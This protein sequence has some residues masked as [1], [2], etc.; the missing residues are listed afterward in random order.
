[1]MNPP[2]FYCKVWEDNQSWI[3]MVTSQKFTLQTKHIALNYHY[4]KQYVQSGE[5]K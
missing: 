3:A 1:M 5:I 2:N 4:F